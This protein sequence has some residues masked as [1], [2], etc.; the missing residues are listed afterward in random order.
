MKK[1]TKNKQT[2]KQN[3]KPKCI[4]DLTEQTTRSILEFACVDYVIRQTEIQKKQLKSTKAY[5]VNGK[6]TVES[7]GFQSLVQTPDKLLILKC[8]QQ[9]NWPFVYQPALKFHILDNVN[10][11]IS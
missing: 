1:Q 4:V 6:S 11:K 3:K 7:M 5:N 2:N 10:E 9:C 8:K